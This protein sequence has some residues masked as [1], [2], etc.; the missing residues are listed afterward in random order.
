MGALFEESRRWVDTEVCN[1]S[2]VDRFTEY[3][4]GVPFLCKHR[5][6][7]EDNVY[8]FG[9]RAFHWLWKLIIDEM[10]SSFS[11][12]EVG[13]YKGQVLSL[14]ALLAK[15][16]RRKAKVYGV[17][18]LTSFTGITGKFPP[19]PTCDYWKMITELH[20]TMGV[21]QPHLLVYDSTSDDAHEAVAA[22]PRFDVVYIDGCHE[23]DYV[24]NDIMFYKERIKLGGF[25][26]MDDASNYLQQP[27]GYFQGIEDVSRA[28]R[29][30]LDT[31]TRFEHLLACMHNRVWVRVE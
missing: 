5:N 9:E 2:V 31:D 15:K 26:V 6:Y 11:M 28:V 3:V 12:L 29:T 4:N 27:W 17:T 22:L 30:G 24:L 16:T 25:L 19:G 18:M 23:Y 20:D 7:I 21:P 13:V 10:P 1:R 14:V 8:G